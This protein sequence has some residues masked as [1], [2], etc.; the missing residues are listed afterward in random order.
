MSVKLRASGAT[1]YCDR[2]SPCDFCVWPLSRRFHLLWAHMKGFEF[3]FL[4]FELVLIV[5]L[6]LFLVKYSYLVERLHLVVLRCFM[7]KFWQ[8]NAEIRHSQK[9]EKKHW[10]FPLSSAVTLACNS[11]ILYV[12]L[13]ASSV[14]VWDISCV[15]FYQ[16]Y[17]LPQKVQS[18][19]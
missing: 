13:W 2:G 16:Q 6:H 8:V 14:S 4:L 15:S 10:R 5:N 1:V 3:L 17:F 18:T 9:A 12:S 7:H 19:L 11:F